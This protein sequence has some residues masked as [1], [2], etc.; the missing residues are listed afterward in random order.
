MVSTMSS[1]AANVSSPA[2]DGEMEVDPTTS[3]AT[4]QIVAMNNREESLDVHNPTTLSPLHS[5]GPFPAESS[6]T[7]INSLLVELSET[8]LLLDDV[9][10]RL[11]ILLEHLDD[12]LLQ[13]PTTSSF[14]SIPATNQLSS[15]E[16]HAST[17]DDYGN[18]MKISMLPSV[19]ASVDLA[20]VDAE[21]P[22]A[23][24]STAV[25]SHK[26]AIVVD[27]LQSVHSSI[28]PQ[29]YPL[30]TSSTHQSK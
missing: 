14:I 26:P 6:P 1:S 16:S 20:S 30:T 10:G 28:N 23:D 5:S 29:I 17:N 11:D 2:T 8:D 4:T 25:P 19:T 7:L 13:T 12:I 27:S 21:S 9:E 3:N 24:A 22:Y 18:P 15:T